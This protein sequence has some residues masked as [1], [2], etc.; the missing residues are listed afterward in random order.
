MAE[1]V[2][3]SAV[4]LSCCTVTGVTAETAFCCD[5]AVELVRLLD[6]LESDRFE[7]M[8]RLL[9][10]VDSGDSGQSTA[11]QGAVDA[12]AREAVLVEAVRPVASCS[13]RSLTT[14]WWPALEATRIGVRP[15]WSTWDGS[16]PY[17]SRA[18]TTGSCPS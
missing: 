5:R 14:W 4:C 16:A 9:S 17:S 6:D 18:R 10:P 13:S 2:A 3:N 8:D 7:M 12:D 15:H 1:A 11:L